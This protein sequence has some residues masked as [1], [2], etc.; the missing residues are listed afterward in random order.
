MKKYDPDLRVLFHLEALG[1]KLDR[2]H[3]IDFFFYFPG[4]EEAR[5]AATVLRKEGFD[6][7]LHPLPDKKQWSCCAAKEMIPDYEELHTLR[8]WFEAIAE[9]LGGLYDGWG[10]GV[11]D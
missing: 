8:R 11:V 3:G 1:S 2:L 7:E 5:V 9:E 10:T 6:V 4:E